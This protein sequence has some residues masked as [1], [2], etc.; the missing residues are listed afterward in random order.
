MTNSR[1]SGP[2]VQDLDRLTSSSHSTDSL[3][4]DGRQFR[5]RLHEERQKYDAL[6]SHNDVVMRLILRVS[7]PVGTLRQH[8]QDPRGID[9][10][11]PLRLSST[12][13]RAPS[14][15]EHSSPSTT[16]EAE[17][18]AAA[19]EGDIDTLRELLD[20]RGQRPQKTINNAL[21]AASSSEERKGEHGEVARFLLRQGAE[22]ECRDD[23]YHRTPLIWAVIFGREDIVDI[24]LEKEAQIEESDDV[25]GWT[26]L[27]W[28]VWCGSEVIIEQLV[29]WGAD[30][31]ATGRTG[32]RTSLLCAAKKGPYGA[33]E[34]LLEKNRDLIGIGNK[35]KLTPLA[36]AFIEQHESVARL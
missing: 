11:L 20:G 9:E 16:L 27:M 18:I 3:G 12:S 1:G 36:L 7:A 8:D 21:V 14:E 17:F 29:N 5:N 25:C 24:L 22:I 4:A 10:H 23:A 13:S 33:A 35:E 26:P 32:E 19:D 2:R 30:L 15:T 34:I 31:E 6:E 28:A